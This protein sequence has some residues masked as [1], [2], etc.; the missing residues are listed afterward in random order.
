MKRIQPIGLVMMV[1]NIIHNY[2]GWYFLG[3]APMK[4]A[5]PKV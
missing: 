3:G 4:L 2:L 1:K 5:R